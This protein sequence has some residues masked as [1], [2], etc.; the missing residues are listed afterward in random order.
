LLDDNELRSRYGEA[1]RKWVSQEFT[2]DKMVQKTCRLYTHLLSRT[3][4]ECAFELAS[5]YTD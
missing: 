3:S 1:A 5:D 4:H 2:L